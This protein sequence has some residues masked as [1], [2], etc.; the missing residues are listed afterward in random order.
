[1]L[2]LRSFRI[3]QTVDTRQR[4]EDGA[5]IPGSGESVPCEC[6]GRMIEI[7][8]TVACKGKYHVV[9]KSCCKKAEKQNRERDAIKWREHELKWLAANPIRNY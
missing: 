5:L 6:C 3:V 8:V 7:H 2:D 1:M 9:G 4:D